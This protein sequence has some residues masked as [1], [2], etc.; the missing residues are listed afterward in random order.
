MS[1]FLQFLYSITLP[2]DAGIL[3]KINSITL[4]LNLTHEQTR[5]AILAYLENN[6]LTFGINAEFIHISWEQ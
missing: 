6:N 3:L 5:Q 1:K 4:M 2:A